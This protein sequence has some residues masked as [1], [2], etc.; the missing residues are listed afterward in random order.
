MRWTVIAHY[1]G[2][3]LKMFSA[4]LLV[5]VVVGKIYGESFVQLEPFLLAAFVAIVMGVLL[6]RGGDPG[7]PE[8]LEAMAAATI[9]W[10]VAVGIGAIPIAMMTG[11]P[12][13]DAYFEAMSGFTTTGMSILPTIEGM[14]HSLLFW[15]VFIQWIGGLGIITFFVTV[16]I[17]SGGIANKLVAVESNKTEAGSIRASLF[18]AIKSMWYVYIALTMIEA[19]LLYYFDF[20]VFYAITH[21]LATLPTGGFAAVPDLNTLMNPGAKATITIF[22]FAGGTNFL[23]LYAL[24]KGNIRRMFENYE[25]RLYL[26][27][28]VGAATLIFTDIALR[29]GVSSLSAAST[30]LFHTASYISSTG[31]ELV[32]LHGMPRFTQGLVLFL[33]FVGASLGST[34]GGIKVLRLGVMLKLVKQQIRALSLPP[35]VLNPVAVHGRFIR[36]EELR[37]IMAIVFVWIL[38]IVFGALVTLWF[39]PLTIGESLQL[40]ASAAGTMGPLLITNAELIALPGVVKVAMMVA[41]LAGR[42]EMLPLLALL[43]VKIAEKF[44]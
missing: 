39:A 33:M 40:F 15:R 34:T 42:L 16:L 4:I 2:L 28:T 13:I 14:P 30:A 32:P 6:G 27:I 29:Q 44:V 23:L 20:P 35:T 25:F 11:V 9:G 41:M 8:V 10:L 22:M 5:P 3:F 37:Q 38:V 26:F 31:F 36:D 1:L 21:A 19:V 43:N 7:R 12:F 18:N 24:L 17:E